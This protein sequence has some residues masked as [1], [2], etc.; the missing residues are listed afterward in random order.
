MNELLSEDTETKQQREK[1]ETMVQTLTS[2][3]SF[4]NEVRDFY[5]EDSTE[6]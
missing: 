4:L 6:F 1:T 2:S 5:F 3:L